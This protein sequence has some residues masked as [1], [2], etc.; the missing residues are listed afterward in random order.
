M[1]FAIYS[2]KS[3]YT[4][5][6]E[7]IGNQIELCKAYVRKNFDNVTEQDFFLYEDEG[8]SGKNLE[9]P[10]FKEL[11]KDAAAHRF[12]CIVCYRLDRISRS[13]VDFS[14][15]VELFSKLEISFICIREQF[16]TS[17][18]MG[19]AMMYIASVFAQLERETIAERVRDNMLLLA[20]EGR[21]LGGTS[22]FGFRSKQCETMILDGKRKSSFL[23]ES[24]PEEAKIVRQIFQLFLSGSSLSQIKKEL[25]RQGVLTRGG[26]RF[27]TPGI[28]GILS[29]PV[30]AAADHESCRY[31]AEAGADLPFAGK[32]TDAGLLCYHKRSGISGI[33]RKCPPSE[34]VIARGKHQ[35]VVSGKEWATAQKLL[36][37]LENQ[38]FKS[39]HNR[40]AL[41]SG[42][43]FCKICGEKMYAKSRSSRNDGSFDYIC[44]SKLLPGA[45]C[46]CPNLNGV[47]ADLLVT[48]RF[49]PSPLFPEI[50]KK[51]DRLKKELQ[52]SEKPHYEKGSFHNNNQELERLIALAALPEEEA[53]RLRSKIQALQKQKPEGSMPFPTESAKMLEPEEWLS[54][55][56]FS[57]RRRLL[58]LL[59]ERVEW[60]GTDLS[61][62]CHHGAK[63]CFLSK[64]V[65]L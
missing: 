14:S 28:R 15:L 7:S 32:D 48:K 50:V 3:K 40:Y 53:A 19:R 4:G 24:N 29:N 16:D 11:L 37:Q 58:A 57:E 43:L 35:S 44:K 25:D 42:L 6:G 17:T 13:V 62:I 27:S 39:N 61:L 23:L 31:L 63:D 20:R 49:T 38:K 54:S 26:N 60:N 56:P 51:L 1:I 55:L 64:N 21:W 36:R 9:R 22:P 47:T 10:Q 65:S 59:L 5:K 18:P 41:L 30:Y 12:G 33:E 52:K 46:G 8:F 2:R 45:G 34:W